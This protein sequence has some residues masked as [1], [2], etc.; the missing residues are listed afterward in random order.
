MSVI[1]RD[2]FWV[3]KRLDPKDFQ[4]DVEK[5]YKGQVKKDQGNFT[6]QIKDTEAIEFYQIHFP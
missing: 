4:P 5:G 2:L 1:Y 6:T 3:E